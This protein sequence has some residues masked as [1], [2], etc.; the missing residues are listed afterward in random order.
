MI[1]KTPSLRLLTAVALLTG[2]AFVATGCGSSERVTKTTT[3]QTT[4]SA[5]PPV[6]ST[7]TTIERSKRDD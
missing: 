5:P 1:R 7:T 3:E 6:S 4:I 2:T